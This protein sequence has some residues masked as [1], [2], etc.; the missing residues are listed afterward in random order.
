MTDDALEKLMV[1]CLPPSLIE[2]KDVIGIVATLRLVE[3][4]GGTLIVLPRK[5]R[6]DHH[7]VRII[8]HKAAS[9]L[10][11]H[12]SGDRLYVPK[13][14]NATRLIRDIEIANKYDAGYSVPKLAREYNLS[15]RQI[16]NIF[17]RPETLQSIETKQIS[18]FD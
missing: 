6:D 18:L 10:I 16:W 2:I 7:L 3:V 12:Y 11:V 1:N 5:Y 14:D 8:G 9:E 15:E 13:N 17:K 4:Y